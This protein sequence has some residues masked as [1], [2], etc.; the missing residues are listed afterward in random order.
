M[1]GAEYFD[2]TPAAMGALGTDPFDETPAATGFLLP[3]ETCDE[4]SAPDGFVPLALDLDEDGLLGLFVC[5]GPDGA[6]GPRPF[7]D[8]AWQRG[9]RDGMSQFEE[10]WRSR[11]VGRMWCLSLTGDSRQENSER[12]ITGSGIF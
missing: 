4:T 5:P 2:A 11:S 1:F 12:L 9:Q 6:L 10:A 3:D 7:W 8:P